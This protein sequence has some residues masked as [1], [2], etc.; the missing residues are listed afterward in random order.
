M[1]VALVPGGRGSKLFQIKAVVGLGT[2]D[3]LAVVAALNRVKLISG[4]WGG[5]R[6]AASPAEIDGV[7]SRFF[8]LIG[9]TPP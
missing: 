4:V 6:K 7:R 5:L 1:N 9:E 3:R 2:E 8:Q